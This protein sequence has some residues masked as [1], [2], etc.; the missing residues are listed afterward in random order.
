MKLVRY[1]QAPCRKENSIFYNWDDAE[2]L[3]A[4]FRAFGRGS[5]RTS[6]FGVQVQWEDIEG[7]IRSFAKKKHPMALRLQ[8][9]LKLANAVEEVGWRDDST[10]RSN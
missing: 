2:T 1:G 5:E 9:A 4:N 7:Y 3:R 8:S 10:P 6:D